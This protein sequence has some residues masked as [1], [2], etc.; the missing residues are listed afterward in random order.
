[1]KTI[2]KYE[3]CGMLG[4]GGMGVV[5]KARLHVVRRIVALK[6]LAPQ[7]IL[8]DLMGEEAVHNLFVTEAVSMA[9]LRHANVVSI[10]DFDYV[11]G[12]P[13]FTMEY[14]YQNLGVLI[15]ENYRV[16]EPSRVLSLDKS[17]H[18]THQLLKGLSRLHRA[19]V[20]HRD[21]KPYNLLITDEDQLKISDFGLSKL[22]G[23]TTRTPPGLMVGSPYY[24]APEQEK[25]PERVDARADLYSAGVVLYRMLTGRLPDEHRVG[26]SECHP[27]VDPVWDEFIFRAI[28]NDRQKRFSS[29]SEMLEELETLHEAWEEK[30]R[31]LCRMVISTDNR[32]DDRK[33]QRKA[34]RDTPVK[35]SP[36]E[37]HHL[38]DCDSLL[39]PKNWIDNQ[40]Q[41]NEEQST[42]FDGATGLLWQRGGSE[43]PLDWYEA[44][45]YV[46]LLNREKVAG[47]CCWR[48]PTVDEL[49]SLLKPVAFGEEECLEAIFDHSKKWLWGSDRRSFAAAWFV[50]VELGFAGWG[51]FT[52]HYFVRAVCKSGSEE[53]LL[54]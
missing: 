21:I 30:K 34:L 28:E 18:Y 31:D 14:Y 2:G 4:R 38:F 6:Y 15:G 8:L 3:I 26:P 40:F 44:K 19:G 41:L 51:D 50:N 11:E 13:F 54:S 25:D 53:L 17:I 9:S 42:V 52:C 33:F 36:R 16:E 10:L 35:V 43:D 27:D 12:H 39:R 46:R 5:Y 23:E 32:P 47:Q 1:L 22:R 29:A 45:A 7:Q 49:F 48:L 20:V 37:A 24:A